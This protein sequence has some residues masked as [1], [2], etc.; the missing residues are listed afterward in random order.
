[1]M[2]QTIGIT[3]GYGLA[4]GMVYCI[5]YASLVFYDLLGMLLGIVDRDLLGRARFITLSKHAWRNTRPILYCVAFPWFVVL[6]LIWQPAETISA[7]EEIKGLSSYGPLILLGV[8]GICMWGFMRST[9][10]LFIPYKFEWRHGSLITFPGEVV[11]YG[12]E[13]LAY[14]RS[15]WLRQPYQT[16]HPDVM[17]QQSDAL[18]SASLYWGRVWI[19]VLILIF[20]IVANVLN[21]DYHSIGFFVA[22][23]LFAIVP[24]CGSFITA[25]INQFHEWIN[26]VI[27]KPNPGKAA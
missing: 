17:V 22:L 21:R 7:I 18:T 1:M 5:V 25:Q 24:F 9:W 26:K 15:V 8:F 14:A 20:I 27:G 12:K 10:S 3:L 2:L 23:L 13:A 6:C 16:P 11:T 4:V 19:P